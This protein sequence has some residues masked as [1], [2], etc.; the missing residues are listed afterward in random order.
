MTVATLTPTT[1]AVVL[2]T[3]PAIDLTEDEFFELCQINEGLVIE[4]S[5]DG[6][7]EIMSP[8]G[9]ESSGRNAIIGA[10]LVMWASKDGTGTVSDSSGGFRLPNGAIRAPDAAWIRNDR[11]ASTTQEQRER[12]LP[13][14]P[15]FIIE[16]RSPSDSMPAL[17]A[18]MEE[19]L[20]NG[21]GLGWLIDPSGQRVEIYRPGEPLQMLDAP[22][23][24]SG[25]PFLPGFVL[26]LSPV[27]Q[28]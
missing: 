12:F 5:A 9:W 6:E 14:C 28:T 15:D 23:T 22:E 1:T 13:L 3:R 7:L 2:R 4:R 16:R 25:D 17:R 20:A 26:D 11:L 8:A 10:Q 18:K 27:W 19:F 24:I 21:V